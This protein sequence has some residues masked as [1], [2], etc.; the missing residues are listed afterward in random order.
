MGIPESMSVESVKALS[1]LLS[2]HAP[3]LRITKF[4]Q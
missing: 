1:H 3:Y 2:E 4:Y